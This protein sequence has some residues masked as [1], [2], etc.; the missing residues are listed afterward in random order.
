M[1][2]MMKT[3]RPATIRI[4]GTSAMPRREQLHRMRFMA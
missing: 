4:A 3:A 2:S 1:S